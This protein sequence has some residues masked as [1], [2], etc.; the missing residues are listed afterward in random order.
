M[1]Q[2]FAQTRP[3][4]SLAD[5]IK[6]DMYA[7]YR[8]YYDATCEQRFF[9]DLADKD[10]VFLLHDQAGGLQ[11]FS[12]LAV[13]DLRYRGQPLRAL[14]SG[15]TIVAH[16]HWGQMALPFAWIR[17]AGDTWA[18]SP[19]TPLYWFLIVKGH[20]TYRYLSAFSRQFYPHWREPTPRDTR[21]LMRFLAVR[22]FGEHFDPVRGVLHFPAS[23][24]HLKSEWASVTPGERQR[25]DVAFFLSANPGYVHGD[26]LVCLTRL[27][28]EN[29]RPL[30]RRLFTGTKA[31]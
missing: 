26:E 4:A 6:A 8:Q 23:R 16:A 27:C 28:P 1:G 19:S 31:A 14:F 30:A 13:L 3:V 11:G 25:E 12:T 17:Y 10:A 9:Q 20:R 5:G 24:G 18:R 15:D 7:L 21:A 22:R 29:L 2:L